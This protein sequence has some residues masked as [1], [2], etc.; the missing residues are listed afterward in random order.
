[1]AGD[2][3][4]EIEAS[5]TAHMEAMRE[6]P[7]HMNMNMGGESS[8]QSGDTSSGMEDHDHSDHDG[9]DH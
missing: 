1:M 6:D 5:K 7:A 4:E 3:P 9:H 2:T 8:E